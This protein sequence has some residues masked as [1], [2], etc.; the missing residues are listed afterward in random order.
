MRHLPRG[1]PLYEDLPTVFLNWEEMAQKL[2]SDHFS[3]YINV[4]SDSKTGLILFREGR[5][6][7]S[8]F[9]SEAGDISR[10]QDALTKTTLAIQE[11]KGVLSIYQTSADVC[12]MVEWYFEGNQLYSPMESYF[13]DFPKFM[14]TL[15]EKK[16]NGLVRIQSGD[17]S[18]F[19]YVDSGSVRGHFVDGHPELQ[20]AS[21]RLNETLSKKGTSVE[22]FKSSSGS[23]QNLEQ[24]LTVVSKVVEPKP[25]PRIETPPPPKQATPVIETKKP[26]APK[27]EP[28][29]SAAPKVEEA[30]PKVE[31]KPPQAPA[32]TPTP[33]PVEPPV[34][35]VEPSPTPS[36]RPRLDF[37]NE[38]IDPFR[39][40]GEF[41]DEVKKPPQHE[42]PPKTPS[43]AATQPPQQQPQ[44]I[45]DPPTTRIPVK[46]S[47]PSPS[48]PQ[49]TVVTGPS[50]KVAFLLD[51]I[52]KVAQSNVGEDIIP[53][54]DGQIS[55]MQQIQP[56]LGKR[57]LL[58]LV[59]EIERY[60]RT[61]RQNPA[62]ATK[63]ASQL[64]H[65]IDS[66]AANLG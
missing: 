1:M 51:G 35:K 20:P 3:G 60:V 42:E 29:V 40:H 30:P 13:I 43:F 5:V 45:M 10:G 34:K 65:I 56:N 4:S 48:S 28:V 23:Q 52:K 49:A 14:E 37:S 44:N 64:R 53:W 17:F 33:T 57:D 11:R 22:I 54:L 9:S 6:T 19:I 24:V 7:G 41:D 32:A 39:P 50:G 66:F 8:L 16:L 47:T 26:E 27:P 62:K 25:A 2:R 12:T 21:E 36:G 15:G 38:D 31:Y 55:R 18:E 63:L 59:D 58:L 46:P 61:V